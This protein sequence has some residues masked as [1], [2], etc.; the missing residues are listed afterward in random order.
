VAGLEESIKHPLP[1]HNSKTLYDT[2]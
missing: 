1:S 2:Y